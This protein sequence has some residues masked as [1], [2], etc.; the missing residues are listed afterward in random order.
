MWYMKALM[1]G[2]LKLHA[3]GAQDENR[4]DWGLLS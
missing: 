3:T 1:M 4:L 2:W